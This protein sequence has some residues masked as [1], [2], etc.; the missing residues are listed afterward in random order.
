MS[1]SAVLGSSALAVHCRV[2]VKI[3]GWWFSG[4]NVG[5]TIKIIHRKVINKPDILCGGTSTSL[6]NPT[7]IEG[8]RAN[9]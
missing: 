3:W 7:G 1:V 4:Q 9:D 5:P 8:G 2:G 6:P